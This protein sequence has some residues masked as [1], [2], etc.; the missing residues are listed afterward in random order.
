MQRELLVLKDLSKYYTSGQQVVMALHQLDL[1]FRQGEFVAIT[2]ESGS[3]KSTLAHVLGGILPYENGELYVDGAPTSHYDSADWEEY[4]RSRV[5]FVS[6]DYG[7]LPGS[8]VL[9]NVVSALRLVGIPD[10]EARGRAEEALR[11]VDLWALR[12]RRAA[13]LSSGQKQRLAIA[14]ALAKPAPILIAD[15]PTGNLDPENSAAVI[16]LLA[17]AAKD[18]LVILITH[19]FDEAADAVTRRVILRDGQVTMDASLRDPLPLREE[20]CHEPAPK[21]KGLGR[22]IAGLQL[23]S[24]PVWSGVLLGLFALTAFGLFAFAGTV[25][26][27][28]DDTFTRTYDDSAFRNGNSRRIVVIRPDGEDF[29]PEEVDALRSLDHVEWTEEYSYLNDLRCG[30]LEDEHYNFRFSRDQV[31]EGVYDVYESVFLKT[32]HMPFARSVPEGAGA[33][34]FLSAGRMPETV[35]EVVA[36]DEALLGQTFPLYLQDEKIWGADSYIC[37]EVTVVG[38]TQQG[39]GL[40]LH[41]DVGRA[42]TGYLRK[43]GVLYLPVYEE[44]EEGSA[45]IRRGSYQIVENYVK[46]PFDGGDTVRG[47]WPFPIK[48][49]VVD[50][51]NWERIPIAILFS[52][53]RNTEPLQR[54]VAGEIPSTL[55]AAV[56]VSPEDFTQLA[57]T[58]SDQISLYLE[59]YAYTDRML[60]ELHAL[61]YAADSPYREG[62][63]IP[64]ESLRQQRANTLRICCG[65]FA[66]VLVLLV[67]ALRA[68]FGLSTDS[69]RV[70][71]HMGLDCASALRSVYLQVLLLAVAGQAVGILAVFVCGAAGVPA[72][73]NI[74]HYL[75]PGWGAGLSLL[76]LAASLL[77]ALGAARALRR[78]LYPNANE[79]PDLDWS[80]WEV[81]V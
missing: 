57:P 81:R 7:I 24:R 55:N 66:A 72:V 15:E 36:G 2:G 78:K 76:H 51:E 71:S 38:I 41:R 47:P 27:N 32:E 60:E 50:Y 80:Q 4:R 58:Q 46:D 49:H 43:T 17:E 1:S 77:T 59:D 22:F 67:M 70:L 62:S 30:Y 75:T 65:A 69:Y 64:V 19:E 37:F 12:G 25:L 44:L 9:G 56:G 53:D 52:A 11:R 21:G 13:K 42:V 29:A 73:E 45:L 8:T 18:R 35:Y 10:R 23:R 40:Y 31:G 5:S 68:L 26:A 54:L 63:T 79:T 61:G 39:S 16:R 14:R 6:Q 28:L 48:L 33:E 3:G 34:G 20:A 74:L